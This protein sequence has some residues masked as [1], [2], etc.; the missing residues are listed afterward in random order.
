[1]KH[2]FEAMVCLGLFAAGAV[3]SKLIFPS[4][5]WKV[6]NI[7]DLFEIFGAVATMGAVYIAATWK[8]QLGHPVIPARVEEW[9]KRTRPLSRVFSF[10]GTQI[11]VSP[12]VMALWLPFALGGS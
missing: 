10:Y 11:F 3:W 8:R 2:K 7:H 4:E 5:F 6:D 1:M 12:S 9:H